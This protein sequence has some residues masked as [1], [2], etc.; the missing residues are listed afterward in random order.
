M[1]AY[2]GTQRSARASEGRAC[3]VRPRRNRRV[4]DPRGRAPSVP[5][6]L[7]RAAESHYAERAWQLPATASVRK[8]Q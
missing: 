1:F 7:R 2:T 3:R 5:S 8:A 4:V 6:G